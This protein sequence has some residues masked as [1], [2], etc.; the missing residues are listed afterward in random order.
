PLGGCGDDKSAEPDALTTSGAFPVTAIGDA[1]GLVPVAT[2][3]ARRMGVQLLWHVAVTDPPRL[4]SWRGDKAQRSC[5]IIQR[6]THDG[7]IPPRPDNGTS[8]TFLPWMRGLFKS[9]RI[10]CYSTGT[11][12]LGE[13]ITCWQTQPAKGRRARA[14]RLDLA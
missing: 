3:T 9:R 7:A 1:G 12:L 4:E 5:D 2:A 6:F 11:R 13:S 10:A 14:D 8:R